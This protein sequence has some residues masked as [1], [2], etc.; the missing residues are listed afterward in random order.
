MPAAVASSTQ[1]VKGAPRRV[2][3]AGTDEARRK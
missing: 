3:A 2:R 1:D